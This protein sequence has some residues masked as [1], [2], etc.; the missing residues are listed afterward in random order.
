M[1]KLLKQL[2]GEVVM[3]IGTIS[4]FRKKFGNNA[5]PLLDNGQI[6][7]VNMRRKVSITADMKINKTGTMISIDLS[8]KFAYNTR[9]SRKMK[10]PLNPD[11]FMRS[12]SKNV[13]PSMYKLYKNEHN[14]ECVEHTGDKYTRYH[15]FEY[16]KVYIMFLVF[17]NGE[18]VRESKHT[19][20]FSMHHTQYLFILDKHVE[21]YAHEWIS[22]Q[23]HEKDGKMY[24]VVIYRF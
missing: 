1:A 7:I 9:T 24:H 10:T 4:E 20:A 3:S 22:F 13:S 6:Y 21:I 14:F 23:T 11:G 16:D 8:K 2:D 19:S 15:P 17:H 18:I 5:V 12:I